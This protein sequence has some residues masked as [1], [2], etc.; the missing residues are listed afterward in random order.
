MHPLVIRHSQTV[1]P[2]YLIIPFIDVVAG[3]TGYRASKNLLPQRKEFKQFG[4]VVVLFLFFTFSFAS[5]RFFFF[6]DLTTFFSL[7]CKGKRCPRQKGTPLAY[8]QKTFE[9]DTNYKCEKGYPQAEV[10]PTLPLPH[11]PLE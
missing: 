2:L 5:L 1:I 3:I 7:T 9:I 4:V 8:F 10:V 6:C 11:L